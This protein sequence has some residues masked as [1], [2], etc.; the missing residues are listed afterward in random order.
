MTTLE[1][2]LPKYFHKDELQ[3]ELE[4]CGVLTAGLNIAGL[5]STLRSSH[6]ME[7]NADLF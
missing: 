6:D 1:P 4:A 3:Y 5:R 2:I 7:E